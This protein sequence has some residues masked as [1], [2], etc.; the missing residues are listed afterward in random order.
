[1]AGKIGVGKKVVI[2]GGNAVGLETALFLAQQGTISPEILHFLVTNRAE[3]WDTL[4]ELANKGN[5]EVTVLEM[6]KYAGKDIGGSTRWTVFSE[7]KR[8]GV[9][10]VT[11]A[12]ALEVLQDG[13]RFEKDGV[14]DTLLAD[15]VVFATGA[16]SEKGLSRDIADLSSEFYIIGDAKEPRNALE[17]IKEGYLTGLKI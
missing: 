6:T 15:S 12:M 3:T 7:L 9:K 5:K 2:I 17:A 10:I 13:I 4:E 11:G 8:L 16:T 14:A 1:L